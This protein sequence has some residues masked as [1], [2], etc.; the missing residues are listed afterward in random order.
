MSEVFGGKIGKTVRESKPWW[1]PQLYQPP[2]G[3][4]NVVMIVLDDVGF[5][6]LGCY[7]V[8]YLSRRQLPNALGRSECG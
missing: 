2:V 4:P 5:A 8:I 1:P 7:G 6:Q 3:K